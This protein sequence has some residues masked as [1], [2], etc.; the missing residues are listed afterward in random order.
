MMCKKKIIA[1]VI[2]L[3]FVS[4]ST[5][6]IWLACRDIQSG[7]Q[8]GQLEQQGQKVQKQQTK[9]QQ[10][11][12][13]DTDTVVSD[14]NLILVNSTHFVNQD[15]ISNIKLTK[16]RYGQAVDE[17]CYPDL[18]RMMDDCRKE[19]YSPI[20]C[21]SFRTNQKQRELYK[22]QVAI[23]MSQGLSEQEAK[24]EAAKSVAI[25]GTSEHEL[26]LAVDIADINNQNLVSGMESQPVQ[27]WLMENCW[28]YGFILRYPP[29][30][31]DIT[32]IVY[33]PW[34]Y[35][36]VGYGAAKYMYENNLTLEE[37]LEAVSGAV[38]TEFSGIFSIHSGR[39]FLVFLTNHWGRSQYR[40][41]N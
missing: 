40:L 11:Y 16:L 38:G 9:A 3:L 1:G 18:Q 5:K 7:E 39:S 10:L 14:W 31:S 23:Y 24:A 2:C 4:L 29:D 35:R 12:N 33:E 30:K 34:H 26:G 17:R 32:G 22:K 28:K 27:Q 8:Q 6:N 21:S 13:N 15:Y 25:P 41:V 20:I 19:G 36:Y 37:Y